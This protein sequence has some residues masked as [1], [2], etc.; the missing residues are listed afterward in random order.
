[1]GDSK[2]VKINVKKKVKDAQG[3]V[4]LPVNFIA[5]GK[6]EYDDVKV[7]VRQDAYRQIERHAASDKT[8]EV[9]GILIG[10]FV[11]LLGK[12][13]VVVSAFIEA[14]YTDS[15]VSTLTFTHET[16]DYIH[17]EH[18]RICPEKKIVGW[19]HTHPSY[20][21]FLSE[22]D[23]FIQENFFNLP[24]QIAYV[25]DPINDSRGFF[26][27]KDKKVKKLEGFYIYD[28]PGKKIELPI[29]ASDEKLKKTRPGLR[30]LD[31]FLAALFCVAAV[32]LAA[33]LIV[34]T[35]FSHKLSSLGDSLAA[36]QTQESKLGS[37]YSTVS[38]ENDTLSGEVS[39]L[40]EAAQS[41]PQASS[42]SGNIVFTPY[43]VQKGDTLTD[44]CKKLN[45]DFPQYAAVIKSVNGIADLNN[46]AVGRVILIPVTEQ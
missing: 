17:A 19:Q 9:G 32:G 26:Q 41:S 29:D 25:V 14:K 38:G 45:V 13:H 18:A 24:W 5:V 2:K 34:D 15:S 42:G 6:V 3:D 11:E 27:W 23:I 30:K 16:W 4:Q 28:E 40:Q 43:T 44:I 37:D 22:Y 8:K 10:D 12:S 20:G 1:M 21:I 35:G 36:A 46:V 39:R 7:Y 33:S 31:V